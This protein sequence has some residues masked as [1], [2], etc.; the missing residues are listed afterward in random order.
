MAGDT[1][2]AARYAKSILDLGIEQNNLDVLFDDMKAINQALS[3]REFWLFIKSPIIK[4]DK[5]Q[6]TFHKIFGES[7]S[8]TTNSFF[9]LLTRKGR[10]FHL[11]EIVD[12][13]IHQY[14]KYNK[15]SEIKLTTASALSEEGLQGI[16]KALLE[17]NITDEKV[18]ITTNVD[19]GLIGGFVIHVEDKLY[20]A[21][22]AHKLEQIRKNFQDNN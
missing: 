3:N 16:R 22:V 2:I 6:K 15:I 21:S 13:F 19:P 5:K 18:E 11:P 4:A 10:E 14:K 8:K 1:R 12:S 17:S 7:L 9:D 20:D